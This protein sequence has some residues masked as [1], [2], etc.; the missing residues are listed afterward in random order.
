[1]V[2]PPGA[3]DE[4]RIRFP[5]WQS[6]PI[7]V[8]VHTGLPDQLAQQNPLVALELQAYLPDAEG[9]WYGPEIGLVVD[10]AGRVAAFDAIRA[11]PRTVFAEPDISRLHWRNTVDLDASLTYR[12]RSIRLMIPQRADGAATGEY[13]RHT[14]Y[15]HTG[16][17]EIDFTQER[18]RTGQAHVLVP[19]G[20]QFADAP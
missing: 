15:T 20:S 10:G 14:V 6:Q 11:G 19:P 9:Q 5:D 7:D 12:P 2:V 4:L 3:T 17:I 8:T 13:A 16:D 1:M 18:I